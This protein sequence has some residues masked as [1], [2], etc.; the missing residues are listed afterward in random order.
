MK[1][2][3]VEDNPGDARLIEEM[4]KEV[5]GAAQLEFVH[6]KSLAEALQSLDSDSFESVLL[7]LG[8]P[9][10]S[11]LDTLVKVHTHAPDMP[12]VVLTGLA[13][14]AVSAEALRRG[15]KD[16]LVKG[17]VDSNVL[18]RA[19]RYATQGKGGGRQK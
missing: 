14:E 3:L 2:L 19:M 8:L 11:G 4:I 7:D 10:S 13:D 18:V 15:A 1:I 17:R 5:E 12:I 6:V 9:D 16:Y